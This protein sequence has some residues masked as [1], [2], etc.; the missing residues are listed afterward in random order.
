MGRWERVAVPPDVQGATRRE[1]EGGH[2]LRYHPSLMP[3]SRSVVDPELAE[4]VADASVRVATLGQKLRDRPRRLLYATLL[5]S[6]S[7]ASSWIE[8]LRDTPRN[9]LAARL[10]GVQGTSTTS[11]EVLRN[12]DAMADAV[13]RLAAA[14]WS[15]DDIH[16]VHDTLLPG[17]AFGAYREEQVYIGGRSPLTAQYVAP[18]CDEIGP[19]MDD[20]LRYV[21]TTGDPPLVAAALVHAQFE[22]VHPYADGNG[23]TGRALFHAV[24]ARSGLVDHGVLP[25]SLVLRDDVRGYVSALTAFRPGAQEPTV[26]AAARGEYLTYLLHAV[27][28]AVQIADATFAEVDEVLTRWA[29]YVHRLRADSSVHRV[30]ELLV[31]QPVVTPGFVMDALGIARATA[32]TALS[33]LERVGIVQRAGG[34][35]RGQRIYQA[36][37]VLA[38]LDAHVPGPPTVVVPPMP[39]AVPV[40]TYG[41]ERCGVPLPRRRVPCTR[42]TGHPGP[43]RAG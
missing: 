2:Y 36:G 13:T 40:R 10:D 42:A 38:V 7:I 28:D 35:F 23:R 34:R 33:D 18:P 20:L 32:G 22:T 1:R 27:L 19:L 39:D 30:I 43:H 37:D 4:L 17:H 16:R 11:H 29:A 15:H 31:D 12:I 41:G 24:L 9:V 5:R 25:L 14:E 8:G 3:V 26:L 6:E 21:R